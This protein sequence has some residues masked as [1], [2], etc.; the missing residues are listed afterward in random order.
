[1]LEKFLPKSK[2]IRTLILLVFDIFVI[3]LCSFLALWVRFDFS[4]STIPTSFFM[5]ALFYSGI[6]TVITILCFAYWHLYSTMWGSAGIGEMVCIVIA[7]ACASLFQLAGMT[8]FGWNMPRSYYALW[9]L[10]ELLITGASRI[11]YRTFMTFSNR[12]QRKRE[13]VRKK[14]VMIVGAG[15]GGALLIRELKNSDKSVAD[16]VCLVDDDRNKQGKYINGVPIKGA[17]EDIIRLSEEFEIDEIYVA[18]PAAPAKVKKEILE[19]CQQCNCGLKILPGLYQLANGEVSVAR[20][21]KVKIEDLLGRD[22][23]HVDLDEIMGY[24]KDQVALVTGGGGSIGSELCRQLADHGVGQL[25]IFDMYENNAYDIQ[26]ELKRS[27]PDLNLVV[28]IGSVRNT[29]R[30]D[31]IFKTYHPDIV[32]HAAAHKHVPLMEDSP[33]RKSVV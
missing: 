10:L 25:I 16:P 9:F 2:R 14:R 19:I 31:S 24:V 20:L 22:S 8:L 7:C 15:Q 29:S 5:H 30:L 12:L 32:Y 33:D 23:I 4:Y 18:I 27:H 21:R 6:C 11:S 1:M 26:Q 17:R 13:L 28:L 3:Q